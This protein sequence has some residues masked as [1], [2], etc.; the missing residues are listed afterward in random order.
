[1][2]PISD[3]EAG[4]DAVRA[5][6]GVFGGPY[7]GCRAAHARGV[8]CRGQFTPTPVARDLTRAPFMQGDPV[9]VTVRFSNASGDPGKPD[10][11]WDSRGMATRFHIGDDDRM[12]I[13]A[14]DLPRFFVR[15]PE[16]F[17]ILNRAL[18]RGQFLPVQLRAM[19]RFVRNHPE[20]RPAL[21]AQLRTKPVRSYATCRYNAL[22]AFAW[23]DGND[24]VRYVRYSWRPE[25]GEATLPRRKAR[26]LPVDYLHQD[27]RDRVGRMPPRPIRFTLEL[28]LAAAAD[29]IDDPTAVWARD[30]GRQVE[31]AGVLEL[32][33]LDD[34]SDE[35]RFNPV[36]RVDGIEA[37]ADRILGFR[38]PA[39]KVSADARNP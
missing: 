30:R 6:N 14:V 12:D 34:L 19:G 2:P 35:L 5:I 17:M 11:G 20:A 7:P 32:T 15:E 28:Q 26:K 37:T 10:F 29:P 18:A 33:A 9:P 16:D 3:E 22:H 8:V 23:E 25:E 4:E 1:V 21:W 39:Y 24:Q 13:V 36:P 31:A 27:I 38:P